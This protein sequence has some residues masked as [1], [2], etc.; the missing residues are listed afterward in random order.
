MQDEPR[1]HDDPPPMQPYYGNPG[2][3]GWGQVPP[4]YP[5]YPQYQPYPQY[6]PPRRRVPRWLLIGGLALA[7]MFA[8]GIGAA[9]GSSLFQTAQAASGQPAA[10]TFTRPFAAGPDRSGAPGHCGTLTVSSVSGSTIT[11]K[12]PDGDTVTI[13]TTSSTQY[14]KAG[15]SASASVVTA[16]SV[17]HVDGTRNSDSSITATRID[18]G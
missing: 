8:L 13:H 4:Q 16:G 2:Q 5:P 9:V 18:V 6:S 1:M 15:A 3:A 12:A 10:G 7:F 17:I 14:T 11:A